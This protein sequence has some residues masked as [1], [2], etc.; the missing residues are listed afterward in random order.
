MNIKTNTIK[1]AMKIE[2]RDIYSFLIAVVV[3]TITSIVQ[4]ENPIPREVGST[5]SIHTTAS[6]NNLAVV[7]VK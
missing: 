1:G 7:R 4:V 5:D 6:N 2:K 3:V